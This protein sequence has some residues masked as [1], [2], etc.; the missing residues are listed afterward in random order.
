[1]KI[2]PIVLK[3]GRQFIQ[4]IV[5]NETL[6]APVASIIGIGKSLGMSIVAEGVETE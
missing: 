3:M 5:E 2:R 4:Q 1:M 6:R